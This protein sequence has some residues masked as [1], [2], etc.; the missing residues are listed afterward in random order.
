VPSLFAETVEEDIDCLSQNENGAE[1]TASDTGVLQTSGSV[2]WFDSHR[3]FGFIIPDEQDTGSKAQ[4]ILVHWSV[5][6]PLGR[7][8]LPEMA[9]V[10]C[11][12]VEAPK[13]LQATKIIHIDESNCNTTP[14]TGPSSSGNRSI[15][16]VDDASSFLDAEVKWFNRAKGYGFLIVDSVDGDIFVHM[17]TLREAAIGE[18]MPGQEL[19]V[20]VTD[21]ERG[22]QA[23]QVCL[24]PID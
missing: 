16:V 21:G 15:H 11:E 12:Y 2:K 20:R 13:G 24:P 5:L 17:E 9:I 22:H 10:T 14:E 8:D 7:R 3:G 6:E 4:D 18:V 19:L 1:N 23:V